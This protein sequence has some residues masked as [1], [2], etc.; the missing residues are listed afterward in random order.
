MVLVLGELGTL[1]SFLSG[2]V[3]FDTFHDSLHILDLLHLPEFLDI[4]LGSDLLVLVQLCL[5]FLLLPDSE[6]VS[7]VLLVLLV[8]FSPVLEHDLLVEC[9]PGWRHKLFF[10][11]VDYLI[12]FGP[13]CMRLV[14]FGREN[15]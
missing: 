12:I 5:Q 14:H 11:K 9:A 10:H 15:V 13:E 4:Q 6:S 2:V 8:S 3:L 7:E 1:L